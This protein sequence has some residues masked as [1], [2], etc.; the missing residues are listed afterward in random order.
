MEASPI[1]VMNLNS[2]VELE[3][4]VVVVGAELAAAAVSSFVNLLSSSK[5]GNIIAANTFLERGTS[6]TDPCLSRPVAEA[7]V[8]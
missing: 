3:I 2:L 1:S 4:S 7:T 5:C 8:P 6:M